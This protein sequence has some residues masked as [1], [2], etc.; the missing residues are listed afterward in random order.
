MKK[1]RKIF[2]V[3]CLAAL[4]CGGNVVAAVS[5]LY[6]G[7]DVLKTTYATKEGY[8]SNVFAKNPTAFNAFV[9]YRLPRNFFVE[10]GYEWTGNRGKTTNTTVEN[11]PG[12]VG[13]SN[14]ILISNVTSNIKITSP[15]FGVGISCPISSLKNTKVAGLIGMSATKLSA[16]L[17]PGTERNFVKRKI[18]PMLKASIEH[19]FT[20]LLGL[21]FTATWRQLNSFKLKS[22]ESPNSFAEVRM[23]D[24]YNFG[25]GIVY[26]F[27]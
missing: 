9:G 19:N 27:Y 26:S 5:D 1:T 21:R 11:L 13:P 23:K 15:Y 14:A 17:N 25:I 16:S 22:K 7:L 10:A 2:A 12:Y 24:G 6:V 8:G 4:L 3:P 18:N 20:N